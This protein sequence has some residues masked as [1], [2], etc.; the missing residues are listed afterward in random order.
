M[1]KALKN[2]IYNKITN[3]KI[4]SIKK[5]FKIFLNLTT[6]LKMKTDKLILIYKT[7]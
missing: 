2:K 4:N 6:K 1:N 5:K 7:I 3:I